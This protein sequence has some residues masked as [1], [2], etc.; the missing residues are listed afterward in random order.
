MS[1][2]WLTL[3]FLIFP[4]LHMMAKLDKIDSDLKVKIAQRIKALREESGKTQSIFAKNNLKD[5]QTLSR[6]ETGRGASIYT[7]NKLCKEFNITISE[8]FDDP[9]FK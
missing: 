5:R 4:T 7:I 6:W 2:K 9:L 8:F 3:F 1:A